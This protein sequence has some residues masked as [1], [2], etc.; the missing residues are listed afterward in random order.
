MVKDGHNVQKSYITFNGVNTTG[1]YCGDNG[2][3]Y[4]EN[5]DKFDWKVRIQNMTLGDKTFP[6]TESD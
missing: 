1:T 6:T 3:L 4:V 5:V 2:I